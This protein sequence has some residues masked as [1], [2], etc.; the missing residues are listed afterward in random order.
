MKLN[1]SQI[2]I[3]CQTQIWNMF[4]Y[5]DYNIN[6]NFDF[7]FY[8][9]LLASSSYKYMNMFVQLNTI[10]IKRVQLYFWPK[11]HQSEI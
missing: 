4:S 8:L 3:I 1:L 2:A 7:E 6:F 9:D 10:N 11:Y 5:T